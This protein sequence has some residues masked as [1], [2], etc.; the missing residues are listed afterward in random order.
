MFAVDY[1]KIN[2]V[3]ESNVFCKVSFFFFF[4]IASLV[5]PAGRGF[6]HL[7]AGDLVCSCSDIYFNFDYSEF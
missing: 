5:I 7:T 6:Q 3:Q 1:G 2:Y 4:L